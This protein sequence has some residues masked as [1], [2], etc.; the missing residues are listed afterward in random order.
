MYA[1]SSGTANWP[2][3]SRN[4]RDRVQ[5][6]RQVVRTARTAPGLLVHAMRNYPYE[7]APRLPEGDAAI[8]PRTLF[9]SAAESEA[10]SGG[11][12]AEVQ[13]SA[14]P[15]GIDAATL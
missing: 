12:H 2:P 8:D 13:P 11:K 1:S 9:L 7:H 14:P 3:E 15:G 4:S 6:A 10:Q 5:A